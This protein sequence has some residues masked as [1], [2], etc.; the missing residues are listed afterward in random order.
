MAC[1]G[2][3]LVKWGLCGDVGSLRLGAGRVEQGLAFGA[4]QLDGYYLVGEAGYTAPG[5]GL[6]TSL[7]VCYGS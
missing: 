4:S 1:L 3:G 2:Q 6:V 7:T 5:T